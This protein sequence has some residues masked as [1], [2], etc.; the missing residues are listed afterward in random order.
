MKKAPSGAFFVSSDHEQKINEEW[1]R[2]ADDNAKELTNQ[3]ELAGKKHSKNIGEHKDKDNECDSR[4]RDCIPGRRHKLLTT[5]KKINQEV[6][7]KPNQINHGILTLSV[8]GARLRGTG[9]LSP[10]LGMMSINLFTSDKIG[11]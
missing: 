2:P 6:R 8:T 9:G 4:S 7:Y 11:T 10:C 3:A 5:D 1:C